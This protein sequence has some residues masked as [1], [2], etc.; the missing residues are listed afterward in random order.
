MRGGK[1][2]AGLSDP[3]HNRHFSR[4]W[5]DPPN[6]K[7]VRP[8]GSPAAE[9]VADIQFRQHVERLHALGPRVIGEML[10][11]IGTERSIMPTVAEKLR[12]YSNIDPEALRALGGDNFGPPPLHEVRR[13]S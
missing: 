10:A 8:V 3:N 6:C 1:N 13:A 4:C 12:R 2:F 9:V 7:G 11:E 5:S